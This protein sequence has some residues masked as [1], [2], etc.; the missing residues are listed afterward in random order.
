VTLG[1]RHALAALSGLLLWLS[2][3]NVFALDFQAWTG[4]VAWIALVP[5]CWA[6]WGQEPL[7]AFRLGWLSGALFFTLSL[8]WLTNVRPMGLAAIPAWLGLA[9]WCGLF[10]GVWGAAVGWVS[11]R[12]VPLPVIA[13][14]AAWALLELVRER[15]FTGFPW[16]NLGSSQAF[17]PAILPLAAITGAVG[18]HFAVALGNM[19]FFSLLI[20]QRL[21]LGFARSAS[22]VLAVAL[23]GWGVQC[24]RQQMAVGGQGPRV[25]VGIIQGNI[26]EDQAWTQAYRDRVMS[27]YLRLSDAAVKDGAKV[28]LWPESSFPGFFNEDA[29]EAK[30]LRA[31]AHDRQVDLLIG[32]TL[33]EG[34]A[35]R[36]AA[37]WVAPDGDT[38]SQAKRH[39]VPFGEYV[40][41]RRAIPILAGAMAQLGVT[42]FLPG[43]T[44]PLFRLGGLRAQPLVCYESIFP[45]L[46]READPP[47]LIAVITED[48][49]YGRS[50]GPVWHASQCAM[51]AVEN[52]AWVARSAATGISL[53]A[54]DQGQILQPI[55]LDQAGYRVAEIPRGHTTF[56]GAHGECFAGL[57]LLL[58]AILVGWE[59]WPKSSV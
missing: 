46:V 44:G 21:L 15:L 52:G 56:Y 31:Y 7:D 26:D 16:V 37:L 38:L 36:N 48:T 32:S 24:A 6:L 34:E 19:V 47:D 55:A 40:P 59:R 39:L 42:D 18:L 53:F 57:L 50:A 22:A 58:L 3:P 9:A 10:V 49:W 25:K 14:A 12:Q 45:A 5:L 43:S 8:S 20:E 29:A 27:T 28:L 2:F 30:Q 17:N 41:F 54:N 13:L 33:S 4:W 1:R 35:Y 51:R 11:R 23:L